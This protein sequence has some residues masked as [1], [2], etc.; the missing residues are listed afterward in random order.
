MITVQNLSYPGA[1][2]P[3]ISKLNED[4]F[5]V[6]EAHGIFGVFD[7]ASPQVKHDLADGKSGAYAVAHMAA[8]EFDKM[9]PN[10]LDTVQRLND[11]INELHSKENINN[12]DALNRFATTVAV[13]RLHDDYQADLLQIGDSPILV[14]DKDGSVVLPLGYDGIDTEIMKKWRQLADRGASGIRQLLSEDVKDLRQQAN[15]AYGMLNGDPAVMN[16]V[17]TTQISLESV[18]SILLLTDGMFLP[19]TDPE[20]PEDWAEIAWLYQEGGLEKIYQTV[21]DIEETDPET[22]KY[23]RYKLHD[24]AT[25]VA[26]DFVASHD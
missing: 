2:Q 20:A 11:A 22:T 21:Y 3:G 4:T 1:R 10:M 19:K 5:L 24:D 6:N 13:V 9:S 25:A 12:L 18:A 7:G 8:K 14:I 16:F 17:K 23:P 15:R 26:I